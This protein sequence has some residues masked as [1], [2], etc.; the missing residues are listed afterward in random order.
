M[1]Y[2]AALGRSAVSALRPAS[3]PWA[4]GPALWA[5]TT[6]ALIAG[7]GALAGNLHAVGLAFLGAACA[8]SFIATGFYRA[9]WWALMG[10]AVGASLGISAGA[11]LLPGSAAGLV[12]TAAVAGVVSGLV[13]GTGPSATAFG[14]MLT[15]GVGF[16]QFGG[17][18]LPWW[19]QV[20]WYLAGTAVAAVAVLAPWAFRRGAPER[21]AVAQVYAAAADLCAAVGTDDAGPARTRL[22][23]A[24]AVVRPAVDRQHADL[25]AFAAATLYVQGRQVPEAAIAAIRQ[26]SNQIRRGDRVTVV[27]DDTDDPGLQALADALSPD[28]VRPGAP[29][30]ATR[31]V[32]SLI[33][34]ATSHTAVANGVRIGLCLAVATGVTVAMHERAHS[35]WLPLT[36][37]VIVRPEYASVFVRTV[38]RIFGTLIG[39]GL[40]TGVLAVCSSGLPL[41]AATALALGF[42]VLSA[43]KLY[44]LSVIGITS[45][46]LLSQSIGQPDP[47]APGIRLLDTLIGAAI[48][49]VFGYLLWPGAR[50]LPGSAR[51]SL[52]LA[53]AR[54]YFD[55]AVKPAAERRHWQAARDDAYRRA[56]Q[57][58]A[59]AE[60]AVLEPPPVSS[61]AAQVIPA[62][63]ELEDVVDAITAVSSAIDAGCDPATLIDDVQRRLARIDENALTRPRG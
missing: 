20:T 51:L 2:L 38:N 35:F 22:A 53:S 23:A 49:V 58:R 26:A 4:V 42:V 30:P 28:P 52:A 60:A 31:R 39:A 32:S 47:V 50:R 46:A 29:L 62:A 18:P 14:I 17:S 55:E 1:G 34:A 7:A 12:V 16:G 43:P 41:V 13:G 54:G 63:I 3:T 37:A 8:A 19:Q 6:A 40:T 44:G 59:I 5:M 61:M 27:V 11:L 21:R 48:A 15:V 57:L 25:V 56:H 33:R 9:R 36:T 24:W 10:Q 45:A